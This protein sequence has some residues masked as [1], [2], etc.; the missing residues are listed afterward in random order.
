VITAGKDAIR[1]GL[2]RGHEPAAVGRHDSFAPL[3]RWNRMRMRM[4]S[5]LPST[6]RSTLG[7]SQIS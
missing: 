1:L 4:A 7:S 6:W 5:V 3:R 2:R